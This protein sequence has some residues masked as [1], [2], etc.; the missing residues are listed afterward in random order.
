MRIDDI[1]SKREKPDNP[2]K[3]LTDLYKR[4]DTPG[5]KENRGFENMYNPNRKKTNPCE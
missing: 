2:A 5:T 4:E 1:I 3:N